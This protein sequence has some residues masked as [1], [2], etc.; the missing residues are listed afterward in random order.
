M[1]RRLGLTYLDT[2]VAL[3]HVLAEDRRPPD[4]L[5][6][7]TLVS[8]R[9]LEFEMW[10]RVNA[11]GLSQSHD[12]TVR[13]MLGRIAFLDIVPEVVAR[14]AEPFPLSVRTLD[15]LHLGTLQFVRDQGVTVDL[16]AYDERM[17]AAATALDIPLYPL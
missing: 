4:D 13:T 1:R 14:A 17:C 9:L 11:R 7:C 10:T 8:S 15:A 5:W 2:S 16:A 12:Q 6:A 3:A